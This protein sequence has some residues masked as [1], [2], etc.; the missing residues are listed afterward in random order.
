MTHIVTLAKVVIYD[1]RYREI[2]P[3]FSQFR[4][5]LKRDFE[6][7]S[8]IAAAQ[9]KVDGFNKKWGALKVDLSIRN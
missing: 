9:N 6:T 7:E 2:Q 1:A 8:F 5:Y 4:A 3:S